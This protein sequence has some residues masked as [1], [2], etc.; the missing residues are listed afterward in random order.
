M[1]KSPTVSRKQAFANYM[2][3]L[4]GAWASVQVKAMF[5][6]FGVYLDGLMFALIFDDRLYFKAD[7]VSMPA[8]V[9][10]G[11]RPFTYESKGKAASL[12]YYEAPSEAYDEPEH[13]IAWARMAHECAVRQRRPVKARTQSKSFGSK[14]SEL[15]G[16]GPKSQEMLSR[17]GIKTPAQL[18]QLGAVM[19]YVRT[20]AVCP[21]ASLNLLWAL[22]GALSG[23]RWQ[24]VAETERASLLMALEDAN[25]HAVQ[26]DR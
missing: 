16:L 20:K 10:R 18:R 23:R 15:Q 14:L 8:F 9:S 19:S 5:G 21:A 1:T 17:A 4:M 24:E 22:E 26:G 2:A 11:L 6:G 7:A 25:K 3:E 12:K 13:M